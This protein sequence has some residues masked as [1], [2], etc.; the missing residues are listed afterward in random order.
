MLDDHGD[1]IVTSLKQY[2]YCP[3]IVYHETILGRTRPTTYKMDD[4]V[5]AHEAERQRAR[6]R[7]LSQYGI[8]NGQR[9]FN[10]RL[11]DPQLRL[12][13]IM[14]EVIYLPDG[15]IIPVDYKVAK[16]VSRSHRLQICAYAMLI[17]SVLG[18]SVPH[19]FVYLIP[20]RKTQRIRLDKRLRDDTLAALE[21]MRH[22]I[23]SEIMPPPIN[24]PAKCTSC[25]FRRFCNDASPTA[26]NRA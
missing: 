3:R 9:V 25:E 12:T 2:G 6:R 15:N 14:D 10:L 24:I 21:E 5:L 17:E 4:G 7:K 11:R 8:D 26:P 22:M 23:T 18:G 20:L 13:G 16:Q 1:L 19:A